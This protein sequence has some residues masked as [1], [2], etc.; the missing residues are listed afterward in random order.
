MARI[1]EFSTK[2]VNLEFKVDGELMAIPLK[3]SADEL[4]NLGKVASAEDPSLMIDWFLNF[5]SPYFGDKADSIT[6]DIITGLM[7]A[8]NAKREELGITQGER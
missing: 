7:N 5:I 1:L 4:K 6:E 2:P 8:W 3:L